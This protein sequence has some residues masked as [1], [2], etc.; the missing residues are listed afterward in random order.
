MGYGSDVEVGGD[1]LMTECQRDIL[2]QNDFILLTT[3]GEAAAAKQGSVET[4]QNWARYEGS[5]YS[6]VLRPFM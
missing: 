1:G 2:C 4:R 6:T 5:I 3:L